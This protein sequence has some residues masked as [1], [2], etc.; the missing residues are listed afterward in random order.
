MPAAGWERPTSARR[1]RQVLPAAGF[2]AS[3]GA[4]SF[5]GGGAAFGQ[6]GIGHR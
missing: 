3:E 5:Q 2:M 6:G 4:E 1:L